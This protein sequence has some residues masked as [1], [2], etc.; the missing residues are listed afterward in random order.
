VFVN[1]KSGLV[2]DVSGVSTADDVPIVQWALTGQATQ[3]WSGVAVGVPA[4]TTSTTST[5][6][7]VPVTSTTTSSTVPDLD[8]GIF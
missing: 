7:T 5:T 6:T 4:P 8:L 2:M 1:C 3:L